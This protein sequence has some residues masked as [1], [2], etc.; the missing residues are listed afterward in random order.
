[1]SHLTTSIRVVVRLV[2]HP[3]LRRTSHLIVSIRLKIHPHT[4]RLCPLRIQFV[5]GLNHLHL[6]IRT[7]RTMLLVERILITPL[8][9]LINPL[10]T[11]LNRQR[12]LVRI[13]PRTVTIRLTITRLSI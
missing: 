3:A 7:N 8:V 13:L 5:T 6:R 9:Q 1:M 4:E 12:F 11:L 10:L 2:I